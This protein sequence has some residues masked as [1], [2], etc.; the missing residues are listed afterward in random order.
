MEDAD[1]IAAILIDEL[2][3]GPA[4]ARIVA[5][6]IIDRLF[7][8][9]ASPDEPLAP[10][11]TGAVCQAC[12][13]AVAEWGSI[14]LDRDR[15]EIRYAGKRVGSLTPREFEL[16]RL[17]YEAKGKIVS[18]ETVMTWLYQLGDEAEIK[19]V[20][21]FICKLKKKV[22]PLGIEIGT[23]WGRGYYLKEPGRA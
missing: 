20:D 6:A 16:F 4:H 14:V 22:L 17:L 7:G 12:G 8:D 9:N 18:K 19:I 21:V 13:Q 1:A 15:A 3:A 10:A 2:E 23:A 11:P 5:K